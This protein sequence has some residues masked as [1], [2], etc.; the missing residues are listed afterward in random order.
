[1]DFL[2]VFQPPFPVFRVWHQCYSQFYK[3]IDINHFFGSMGG[4]GIHQL[5][6]QHHFVMC[7]DE[8]QRFMVRYVLD[9]V[10]AILP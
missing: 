3:L 4:S 1:M 5:C 6:F 7:Q 10:V 8:C 9:Y 2:V